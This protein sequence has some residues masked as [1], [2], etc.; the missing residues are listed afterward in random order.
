MVAHALYGEAMS[1]F[2]GEHRPQERTQ[3][4]EAI[5]IFAFTYLWTFWRRRVP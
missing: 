4:G 3:P 5:F 2:S 1:G